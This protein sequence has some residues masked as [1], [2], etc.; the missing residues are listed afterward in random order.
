MTEGL[1]RS[2]TDADAGNILTR[3][4]TKVA[5]SMMEIFHT[6]KNSRRVSLSERSIWRITL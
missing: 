4:A 1:R 2:K 3:I 5:E 6:R